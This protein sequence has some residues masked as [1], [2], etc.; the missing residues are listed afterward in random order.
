MAVPK[1][2]TPRA[3]DPLAAFGEPHARAARSLDVP[4][5]RRRRSSRTVCAGTAVRTAAVR[6]STS[7]TTRPA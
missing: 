5:M 7:S 1:R 6:S 4:A 2:K 3:S